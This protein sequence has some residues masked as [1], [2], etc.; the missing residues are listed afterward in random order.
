LETLKN[1]GNTSQSFEAV[2]NAQYPNYAN[3]RLWKALLP[4]YITFD[5]GDLDK[6]SSLL[7]N[8]NTYGA[9]SF[10]AIDTEMKH[11]EDLAAA[12]NDKLF[13]AG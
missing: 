13:F 11:Y 12:V 10:T 8:E 2:F 5:T 1:S 6:L 7:Y 4:S 3:D 9:Y